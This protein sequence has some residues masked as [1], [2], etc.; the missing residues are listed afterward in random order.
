[1]KRLCGRCLMLLKQVKAEFVA[2]SAD[3]LCWFECADHGDM[4][5][6]AEVRR[7]SRVPIVEFFTRIGITSDELDAIEGELD[8][9]DTDPIPPTER[10]VNA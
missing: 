8:E 3:G 1:M 9:L 6:V 10:N 4:D 5:N 7:V 2:E